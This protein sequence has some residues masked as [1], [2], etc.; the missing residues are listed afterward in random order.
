MNVMFKRGAQADLQKYI[1]GTTQA[2]EGSF[3]LTSD[4]NRLYIGK[5]D[6]SDNKIKAFPVNQGVISVDSIGSLPNAANAEAGQFYYVSGANI[7]CVHNGKQWV[8]INPDT[9]TYITGRTNAGSTD[10]TNGFVVITDSIVQQE[11]SGGALSADKETFATKFAVQGNDGVN[12]TIDTYKDGTIDRPVIKISQDPYT[13]SDSVDGTGKKYTLT[14]TDGHSSSDV[15]LTGGTNITFT[16]DSN[17]AVTVNSKNTDLNKDASGSSANNSLSFDA[18]GK[19]TST[20][21][22]SAGNYVSANV[23]PTIKYAPGSDGTATETA[24]FKS[25]TAELSVYSKAQIDEKLRGLDAMTYRGTV[26]TTGKFTSL[27]TAEVKVGDTF[28]FVSADYVNGTSVKIG[29][30]VIANGAEDSST[31]YITGTIQWDIIPSGDDSQKDTTYW[32]QSIEAGTILVEADGGNGASKG[33]IQIVDK[34]SKDDS[35]A[36]TYLTVENES[37]ISSNTKNTI[38]KVVI[39]HKEQSDDSIKNGSG[40]TNADTSDA[41]QSTGNNFTIA[42]PVLSYDKAG[43]ITKIDSKNYTVKDTINQYELEYL[44]ITSA[45]T[46]ADTN[47][48]L[49]SAT[50]TVQASLL[51]TINSTAD[52]PSFNITSSTI[53]L[54]ANGDHLVMD[55]EWGEFN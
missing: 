51:D 32:T 4:T 17:G 35:D 24:T 1:L 12:V 30:I 8:Q 9:N 15:T 54:N 52:R 45:Q 41:S 29:D 19:L 39:K 44:K 46:T 43:H 34:D 48:G 20:I 3:Y 14:I 16:E 49:L 55:I 18:S 26:G 33:G 27:P 38:N 10:T 42:V 47:T 22:D 25:G 6:S 7:L 31:G 23:T 28:K 53:T 50:A 2:V 40:V 11:E 36:A 5:K 37:T 13:I 21:T